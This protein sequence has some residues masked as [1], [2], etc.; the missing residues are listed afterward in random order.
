MAT[1]DNNQA[2]VPAADLVPAERTLANRLSWPQPDP[3]ASAIPEHM[4]DQVLRAIE[5]VPAEGGG[6]VEGILS[7]LLAATSMDD[8][9]AP[10][11]GT[12]GRELAGR[13]LRI[14]SII[15]RPSQFEDG[16]AVFLVA[17]C[18][19]AKTGD[20]IT[21]T[22]S[23]LAVIIQLAMAHNLGW[24]P[25]L[26]DVVVAEKPTERGYYPYHLTVLAVNNTR[27]Q[28]PADEPSF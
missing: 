19:D 2:A 4:L 22:T 18:A 13:R 6:G 20:K 9:N 15:R 17:H 24:M 26:A 27:Q 10:W 12:S 14:E 16:P 23:A 5:A 8:L 11:A 25:L 28:V 21:M 3:A 1:R 7:Q